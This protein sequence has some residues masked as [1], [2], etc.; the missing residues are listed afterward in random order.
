[1]PSPRKPSFVTQLNFIM[2][3]FRDYEVTVLQCDTELRDVLVLTPDQPPDVPV[4]WVLTAHGAE[5][6]PWGRC[7][8]WGERAQFAGFMPTN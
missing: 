7:R 3:A 8:G 5:D 1:M 2:N 6:K 4:L